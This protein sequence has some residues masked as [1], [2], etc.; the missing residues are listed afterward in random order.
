MTNGGV[1]LDGNWHDVW[2]ANLTL[3]GAT[4]VLARV[5]GFMAFHL[6]QLDKRATK[7]PWADVLRMDTA[8]KVDVSTSKK[9]KIYH[10]G[11]ATQRI[12]TALKANGFEVAADAPIAI[13]VR[14]DDN[15]VTISV[16]TSG[17]SLH[18]RGH[19]E[20]VGK[21]PM[22]EIEFSGGRARVTMTM[23][24]SGPRRVESLESTIELDAR[25]DERQRSTLEEI[26]RNCPV[27]L[28][29]SSETELK[30]RFVYL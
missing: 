18:K 30:F 17:E 9:S 6:A 21:A 11:A 22:R 19:K 8:V 15:R 2:R 4:R 1:V 23:S 5:G 29:L 3:R 24:A 25:Y 13:K 20:A 7:F 12:E 16:D 28:S 14:I 27:A 10:A 26:A